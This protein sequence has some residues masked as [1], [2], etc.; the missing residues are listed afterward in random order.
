MKVF[1]Y[2]LALVLL[3]SACT[4]QQI[5][6][7][8]G[9]VLNGGLST[10]DVA[11]GLKE[12]LRLGAT[13]GAQE[14]SQDGGYFDDLAYRILLPEEVQTVTS[15]LQGVPG[16]SDLEAS[17]LRKINQGAEDAAKSA[18]P[19]FVEAITSM[20]IEDAWNILKGGDNAA[21]QYLQGA[22]QIALTEAFRPTI[23]ESLDKFNA[24]Q[25][26]LDAST[27]YNR[28]PLLEPVETDLTSYVTGRALDGLFKKVALKEQDIR[29][30]INARTSDLLRRVFAEQD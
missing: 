9:S 2:L 22:T 14:L 30:N 6:S 7:T 4:A 11:S 15:R 1:N 21:T 29:S 3:S 24:N 10:T 13:Q 18:G 23:N 12:A 20:T 16:F 26:W 8:L 19:I 28:I 25:I 17:I 5:N 27:A